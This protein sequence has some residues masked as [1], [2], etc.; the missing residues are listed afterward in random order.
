MYFFDDVEEEHN[1]KDV[2]DASQLTSKFEN[3]SLINWNLEEREMTP[4]EK[5]IQEFCEKVQDTLQHNEK[6][7]VSP[8]I[9]AGHIL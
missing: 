5:E 7:Y 9:L 2:D 1:D 4:E 6:G 8:D 3:C